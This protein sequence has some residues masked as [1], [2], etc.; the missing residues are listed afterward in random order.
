MPGVHHWVKEWR[1]EI[2]I[3]CLILSTRESH[4][5]SRRFTTNDLELKHRLQKKKRFLKTR[6]QN[7]LPKFQRTEKLGYS[8]ITPKLN[9]KYKT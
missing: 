8:H 7:K 3:E 2:F 9:G 1:S 5:N 6:Y 4:R